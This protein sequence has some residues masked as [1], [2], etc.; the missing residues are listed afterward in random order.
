MRLGVRTALI[1]SEPLRRGDGLD[2]SPAAAALLGVKARD[3]LGLATG[4][5]GEIRLGPVVAVF[6]SRG[7][8][9]H[10]GDGR[11]H[12]RVTE[13]VQASRGSGCLVYF[14][15]IGDI[16][17]P[18]QSINGYHYS[19]A[20]NKWLQREFP[21]PDV[22][23][24]RAGGFLA[25]QRPVARYIRRQFALLP[26][27][28]RLNAEHHFNKW[29]V[30]S[31]LAE[32][33]GLRPLLPETVL[34]QNMDDVRGMLDRYDAV[35]LKSLE[36]SNGRE[37]MRVA[38]CPDGIEYGY[39]RRRNVTGTVA[40]L[41]EL[42]R[43]TRGFF[44]SRRFIVQRGISV[45]TVDGNNTD[46][47][48]LMQRDGAG[49]WRMVSAPVRIAA[50]RCAI[51]S[52]SSGSRVYTLDYAL[53]NVLNL[54]PL[55]AARLRAEMKRVAFAFVEAIERE[56]GQ[57][58]EL[59]IDLALDRDGSLWFIEVNAKPGKDTV[60]LAGDV[61]ELYNAFRLPLEYCRFM[62]DFARQN[63]G[64]VTVSVR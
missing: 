47:R 53:E 40:G 21:L 52:T 28:K 37:V 27:V 50:E 7:G 6:S 11:P 55:A 38:R 19:F 26:H 20:D 5:S 16:D 62:T 2:L 61:E 32:H 18:R 8:I 24:D 64:A 33:E 22:L 60:L 10:I 17:W 4:D 1:E 54:S 31:R 34:Y 25:H 23:Y 48:V 42:E 39:F 14:F 58:G 35:Y 12:F 57:F 41:D 44:G 29:D 45:L 59:G 46:M 51:T 3:E 15:S 56:Y 43:V 13:L 30:H 49:Q 63:T 36:G 9:R